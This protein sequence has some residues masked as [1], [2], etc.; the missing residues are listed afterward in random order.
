[1][2][3]LRSIACWVFNPWEHQVVTGFRIYRETLS[4]FSCAASAHGFGAARRLVGRYARAFN[5]LE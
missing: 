5:L 1:N 2:R 3:A 4:R